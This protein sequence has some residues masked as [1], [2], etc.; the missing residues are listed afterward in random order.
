MFV[1]K[2]RK[3]GNGLVVTVPKEEA[4]ALGLRAGDLADVNIRKAEGRPLPQRKLRSLAEES[5]QRNE[6]GYRY[7]ARG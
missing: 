3:V 5:W 1:G 2:I 7:L 6:Q 4:E